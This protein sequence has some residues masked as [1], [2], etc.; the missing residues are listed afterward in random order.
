MEAEALQ[1]TPKS[2]LCAQLCRGSDR[3]SA[4]FPGGVPLAVRRWIL[5]RPEAIGNDRLQETLNS[6]E[7][8]HSCFHGGG[9]LARKAR[10]P[11]WQSAVLRAKALT[12]AA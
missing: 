11:A 6:V 7:G 4:L 1:V 3:R 8:P 12:W 10:M 9:S 2:Q 5:G